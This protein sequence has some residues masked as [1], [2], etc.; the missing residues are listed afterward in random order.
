[1]TYV[2]FQKTNKYLMVIG[3]GNITRYRKMNSWI[4]TWRALDSLY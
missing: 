1:V 4:N 2:A 3:M